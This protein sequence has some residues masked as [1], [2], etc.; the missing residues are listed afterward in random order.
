MKD[1]YCLNVLWMF[2]YL[3]SISNM[4]PKCAKIILDILSLYR[5]SRRKREVNSE[6]Q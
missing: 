4:F 5:H 1:I 3:E 6:I 2:K